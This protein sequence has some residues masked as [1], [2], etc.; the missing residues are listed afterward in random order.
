MENTFKE[1][2]RNKHGLLEGV[3]YVFNEDGTINWRKM[4]KPEYL[5][6]NSQKTTET[7]VSKLDD[8][9]LLILLGGIKELA[10]LRGYISVSYPT[11]IRD[12]GVTAVC[13]ITWRENYETEGLPVSFEAMADATPRNTDRFAS[14]YLAAIAENRAFV[15]AV[16]N[17]LKINIV[18]QEEV[19]KGEKQ[20]E[21][22]ESSSPNV[23]SPF[24]MLAN[25][26]QEKGVEFDLIKNRLIKDK[27][28]G[29]ESFT[30]VNDIPKDK[31]Y[32]MIERVRAFKKK[33]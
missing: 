25:L 20:A 27:V 2:K 29:A 28:D 17:F 19:S 22:T 24:D 9:K 6:P 30:S 32:E 23:V 18:S 26:M 21:T 31:I 8:S 14:D 11:V 1:Q 7:D 5:V 3:N 13:R 33:A 4:V 16:R 10:Q 15:R 12:G